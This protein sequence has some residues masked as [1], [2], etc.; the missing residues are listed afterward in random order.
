[1]NI[2]RSFPKRRDNPENL[3][4]GVILII[5]KYNKNT[6]TTWRGNPPQLLGGLNWDAKKNVLHICQDYNFTLFIFYHI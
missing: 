3:D 6:I 5:D 2:G 4:L 1:M